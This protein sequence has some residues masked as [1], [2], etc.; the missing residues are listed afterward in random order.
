MLKRILPLAILLAIGAGV[1]AYAAAS[2]R[3]ER[4]DCPGKIVCPLTG[5]LVCKD[6]CPLGEQ[7]AADK[8]TE[9]PVCCRERE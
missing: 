6:R 9:L 5:E 4:P 7:G 2:A 8:T 1:T 3:S